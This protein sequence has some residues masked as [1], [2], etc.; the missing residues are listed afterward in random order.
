MYVYRLYAGQQS[1]A[2]HVGTFTEHQ[3]RLHLDELSRL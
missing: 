2:T 1:S 3:E